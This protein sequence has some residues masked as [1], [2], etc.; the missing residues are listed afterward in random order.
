VAAGH[1]RHR[2]PPYAQSIRTAGGRQPSG[3]GKKTVR[4][5]V[6]VERENTL[7]AGLAVAGP[8][9]NLSCPAVE[10]VSRDID[11]AARTLREQQRELLAAYMGPG[12]RGHSSLDILCPVFER[13]YPFG[14]LARHDFLARVFRQKASLAYAGLCATAHNCSAWWAFTNAA[15]LADRP[16]EIHLNGEGRLHRISGPAI[17]YRSGLELHADRGNFR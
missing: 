4:I 5:F 3:K 7:Q 11:R 8:Q 13:D 2:S 1:Q 6:A 16:R 17:V 12:R 14:F 10:N 9:A 15:I